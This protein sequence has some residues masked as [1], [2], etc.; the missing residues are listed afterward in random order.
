MT[1]FGGRTFNEL[2]KI[3]KKKKKGRVS[4]LNVT[5]VLREEE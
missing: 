4:G 3:K 5:A 1:I 2:T